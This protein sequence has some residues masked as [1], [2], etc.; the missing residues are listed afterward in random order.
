MFRHHTKYLLLLLIAYSITSNIHAQFYSGAELRT[1]EYFQYGRFETRL[2]SPQGEG[3]LASF[4]TY[5][6]SFPE[7]DWC[8]IDFE[9]LG[10]WPDN[11]DVNVI[12]ERGSHLRQH[13]I[14]F[15]PHIGFHNYAFE[16]T[17]DYVAWFIDGEEFYRQTGEHVASLSQSAKL[18]MN[19]WTPSYTDW[20]GFID[21]STMPR[22]AYY[23]WVSCAIYT[24]GTGSVGTDSNFSPLWTDNFDA[25]IDTLWEKSDDHTWNGN[26]S[27]LMEEN[28][29][30]ED[31]NMI[32][33]L[34]RPGYEGYNDNTAPVILWARAHNADSVVVRFNKEL[35]VDHTNQ[36]TI[37]T[38]P[39]HPISA[40]HLYEDQR[41]VGLRIE[42][43]EISST[44]T[45]Y[46]QNVLDQ[47]I[48]QNSQ[49]VTFTSITMPTPLELPINID[50]AGPGANGFLPDQWWSIDVEYGHDGGNYQTAADYPDLEGTDLDSVMATSL[51]R[52]S[53]YHVRLAPGV[54]DIQLHF[55]EHYYTGVGER[56]FELFVEDSL[57]V[58]ELDVYEQSGN[59]GIF[60][61]ALSGWEITD[62][63]L[64]IVGAALIYGESYAYAGPLLNAI[65]IDGSYWVGIDKPALPPQYEL[66]KIF[67]NPFNDSTRLE[68][69]I[70]ETAEVKISL[71]DLRG[72]EVKILASQLYTRGAYQ[73]LLQGNDLSSGVYFVRFA[74]DDFQ[75]NR[76][77]LLLK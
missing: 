68:F 50:C 44:S 22:Y 2:K 28:I 47:S 64:D 52:Y 14:N 4:F 11:V 35:D 71:F 56:V 73:L 69:S 40:V 55:A 75:Q 42:G 37:F 57:V 1:H 27:V 31:G 39:N 6:D 65:Q 16:W 63:T 62:G 9:V 59:Y 20:V 54:F 61:V 18:M 30:Y 13:P 60:T 10:R 58:A 12:D 45:V 7:T 48:N 26:N 33:C 15:N 70:P 32:L 38:I 29:V 8:E 72:A 3:F 77:I 25:F 66:T 67:P 74:T 51:N 21:P 36:S 5:N 34:T 41:T 43:L 24:P 19:I 53:R 23:D 46:A 17:P 76:K 49:A